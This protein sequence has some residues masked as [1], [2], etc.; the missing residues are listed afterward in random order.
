MDGGRKEN[1]SACE[2]DEFK[3][4]VKEGIDIFIKKDYILFSLLTG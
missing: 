4:K 3:G 2:I 1:I